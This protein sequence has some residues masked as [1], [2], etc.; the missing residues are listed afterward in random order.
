MLITTDNIP[1]IFQFHRFFFQ[2]QDYFVLNSGGNSRVHENSEYLQFITS[3]NYSNLIIPLCLIISSD[4]TAPTTHIGNFIR[5]ILQ[6][7]TMTTFFQVS[8]D[9]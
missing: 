4:L 8:I 9:R 6:S 7:L 1:F 2:D 5:Q 3:Y